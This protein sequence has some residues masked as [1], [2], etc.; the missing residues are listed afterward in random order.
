MTAIV[1]LL[2]ASISLLVLS[3][4]CR[5]VISIAIF[6]HQH[7]PEHTSTRPIKTK[8]SFH[9]YRFKIYVTTLLI[10]CVN[11]INKQ[12]IH[13]HLKIKTI[14][15]WTSILSG[16]PHKTAKHISITK[17]GFNQKNFVSINHLT[18]T[19][20][21]GTIFGAQLWFR[22]QHAKQQLWQ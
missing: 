20:R 15:S 8:I 7:Q 16:T 10:S 6:N 12:Q 3:K 19:N 11:K 14:F 18:Y 22:W 4:I 9:F 17:N 1:A 5:T 13:L 2:S 21:F